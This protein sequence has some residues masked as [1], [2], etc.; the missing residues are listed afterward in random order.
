MFANGNLSSEAYT[1]KVSHHLLLSI[2]DNNGEEEEEAIFHQDNA[3]AHSTGHTKEWFFDKIVA[4]MK[5][6]AKSPDLIFLKTLGP[7]L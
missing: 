2:E 4:V 3:P 7:G 1:T 6:S 5:L